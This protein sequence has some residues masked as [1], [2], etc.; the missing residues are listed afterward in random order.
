MLLVI[1]KTVNME[2]TAQKLY[3]VLPHNIYRTIAS[4]PDYSLEGWGYRLLRA[5]DEKLVFKEENRKITIIVGIVLIIW[6]SAY[7]SFL[8]MAVCEILEKHWLFLLILLPLLYIAYPGI[9]MLINLIRQWNYKYIYTFNRLEG[10][11]EYLTEDGV[12]KK[13]PFSDCAFNLHFYNARKALPGYSLQLR[14]KPD[15]D[16]PYNAEGLICIFSRGKDTDS[17]EHREA[18]TKLHSYFIWYMDKNRSLPPGTF[19]DE[20]R[21]RD[22]IRRKK[23][24]NP[25]PL[26]CDSLNYG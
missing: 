18:L 13:V 12:L 24:G 9:K 20:C 11:I 14:T 3:G 15:L 25:S 2:H 21:E 16:D 7:L 1:R 8:V 5:D 26:Y 4:P 17:E 19:T 22:S 23:E 10:T 6:N